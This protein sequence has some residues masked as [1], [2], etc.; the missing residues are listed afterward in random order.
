MTDFDELPAVPSGL[1]GKPFLVHKKD[2]EGALAIGSLSGRILTPIM[3]QPDWAEGLAVAMLLER[4]DFYMTRLGTAPTW[5]DVLAFEDLAWHCV[6][7]EGDSFVIEADSEFRMDTIA[8]VIG[9]AR[10]ADLT[11]AAQT[12]DDTTGEMAHVLTDESG[13]YVHQ[14]PKAIDWTE[15]LATAEKASKKA[16]GN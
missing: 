7:A 6:S 14:Q 15:A 16:T 1:D 10:P 9:L 8:E 3:E 4:Y 12:E 2:V 5:P 13:E 11:I